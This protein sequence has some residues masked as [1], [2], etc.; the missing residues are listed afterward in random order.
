MAENQSSELFEVNHIRSGNPD[1]E[2]LLTHFK[3]MWEETAVPFWGAMAEAAGLDLRVRELIL[4]ALLSMKGWELGVQFH[5]QN[6]LDAGVDVADIRG[7]IL[8]TLGVDGTGTA[9]RGLLWLDSY[10]EARGGLE[11]SSGLPR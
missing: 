7:A 5:A 10:L 6:A 9:A 2:S 1:M 11:A 8:L 4:I 3:N